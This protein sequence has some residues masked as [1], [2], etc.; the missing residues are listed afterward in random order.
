MNSYYHSSNLKMIS[1][2]FGILEMF[3]SNIPLCAHILANINLDRL[4]ARSTKACTH[5][6]GKYK[7][8]QCCGKLCV[9][10]FF[11]PNH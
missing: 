3:K 10:L 7:N 9:V 8:T 2:S 4:C 1:I 5:L 6:A 11:Q